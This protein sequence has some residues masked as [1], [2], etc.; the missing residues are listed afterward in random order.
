MWEAGSRLHVYNDSVPASAQPITP[1]HLPEARHQSQL[2]GS[3]TAPVLRSR[4]D[5]TYHRSIV[6][7]A[8]AQGRNPIGLE[9]PGF[10]G[11]YGGAENSD[12]SALYL[13]A[14]RNFDDE[15]HNVDDTEN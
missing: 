11:L 14:A 7:N 3:Y 13:E 4:Q 9:I 10:R 15:G 1:R 6:G 8:G 12:D 5:A 2:L